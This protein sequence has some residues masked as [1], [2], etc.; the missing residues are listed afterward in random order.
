MGMV[1]CG[2]HYMGVREKWVWLMWFTL[3]GSGR[4]VGM[5]KSGLRFVV[6]GEK[7]VWVF[8]VYTISITW[9]ITVVK[10]TYW[11]LKLI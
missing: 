9:R 11:Y 2:L 7:W 1:K 6:V 8:L 10:P 5:N 3:Y 4:K